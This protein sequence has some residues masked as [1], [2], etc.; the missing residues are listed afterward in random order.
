[1]D[2]AAR[3]MY[4]DTWVYE[5]E[6]KAMVEDIAFWRRLVQQ[7]DAR[8]VLELA[9][10]TGRITIPIAR[11]LAGTGRVVG[12]DV[13]PEM[14]NT[15]AQKLA[16]ES[17]AVQQTARFRAGDMRD[18]CPSQLGDERFDLIFVPYNSLAHLPEIDDQLA[19]FRRAAARLT[20]S[21]HFVVD[22]FHPN[23]AQLAACQSP[24]TNGLSL[25]LD[26]DH[27]AADVTR[28]LRYISRAY[29]A[30]AQKERITFI[31]ECFIPDG[32]TS[33][34]V[35]H[36]DS[37][38]YFPRE[39]ELLFRSAGLTITERWGSYF[40]EPFTDSSPLMLFSAVAAPLPCILSP[41]VVS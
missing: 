34:H 10:G 7:Y 28:L 21:G 16:S 17:D 1:M 41:K 13:S 29:I 40:G 18:A 30:D 14:I 33:K 15:A 39:L 2:A 20:P 12:L 26:L 37:H 22:V 3:E 9:C 6:N 27:P 11:D 38:T 36:F 4:T 25:N 35:S 32:R 19:A 8:S 23:L 24:A 5:L 31:Y